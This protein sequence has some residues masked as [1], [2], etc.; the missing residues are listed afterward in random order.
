[1]CL[2]FIKP[3]QTT[4]FAQVLI[5][6]SVQEADSFAL[7][8]SSVEKYPCA[9][10]MMH[11]VDTIVSYVLKSPQKNSEWLKCSMQLLSVVGFLNP[12]HILPAV[13][14][15]LGNKLQNGS[16]AGF[17]SAIDSREN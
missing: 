14:T 11:T 17:K 5:L 6:R 15:K 8:T 3:T 12:L 10:P 9:P 2:L 1:M 16:T 13:G 7:Y 4:G